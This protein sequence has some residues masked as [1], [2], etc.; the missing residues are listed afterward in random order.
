MSARPADDTP[1]AP[2][3]AIHHT[4][5]PGEWGLLVA[6]AVL[7]A[8]SYLYVGVA[9]KAV[10]PFSLVA[11]R[12]GLGAL[13]LYLCVKASGGKMPRDAAAW[14][15]FFAMGLMN[16]VIP[17]SL[18]AFGQEQV[19]VGLA[20]IINATTPLFTVVFAHFM[21]R[22]ERLSPLKITGVIIGF[23]GVVVLIGPDALKDAGGYLLYELAPLAA[24]V[25]Y[26]VSAI[27]GRRAAKLGVAPLAAA[28]G[29][30]TAAAVIMVPLALITEQP[31]TLPMPGWDVWA[32]LIAL[33]ALSTTVAYI[34]FYRVLATAGSVN[35]MLVTF[36]VPVGAVILGALVLGER[37]APNH[38]LGMLAIGIGL[39]AIDGRLFRM[40]RRQAA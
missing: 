35:L 34:I 31:W 14:R 4:M 20:A 30:I 26:A 12:V 29:Q 16:N 9:V 37:L 27:Y 21:T 10:P 23:L 24:A 38:F 18:I 1:A 8:G 22:D 40:M 11:F 3:A 32:S 39:A 25:F 36:M 7:W 15:V 6:L 5:T 2:A 17:F 33:A 13:L 19:P 28:T